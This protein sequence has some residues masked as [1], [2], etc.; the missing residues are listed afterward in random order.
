MILVTDQLQQQV[1]LPFL[2][3]KI[4]STVPSQTEL[5]YSLGLE[6]AV[7]GITKFCIHPPHWKQ[8][9]TIIG[10]TKN[11]HIDK[12]KSLQPDLV[13]ANKEENLQSEITA[14]AE[15]CPVFVSD[16]TNLP[17]AIDMIA[18]T[19]QLTGT[20]DKATALINTIQEGFTNLSVLARN[21]RTAYL[22]WKNPYMT[23]GQ[24][25]FIHDMLSRCG[26]V[27]VFAD[28]VRYPETSIEQLQSL[29]IELLLLSTE[30]YPFKQQHIE[31][32][33]TLLPQTKIA[34][35]DGEYFSWYG[36]RLVHAPVYFTQLLH[37]F[38]C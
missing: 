24:D 31:E 16:V 29:N 8:T 13:I 38:T 21:K 23:I 18:K 15:F 2:P 33:Q 9:K 17:S 22:I 5:L 32:L 11:L 20:S 25:T 34:L 7:T 36:S 6:Q 10:G 12:I 35:A 3:R 37:H 30:P 28:Q 27:N 19:G 1:Q 4:I 26:L 14:L